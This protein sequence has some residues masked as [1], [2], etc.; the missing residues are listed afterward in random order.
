MAWTEGII[1]GAPL[2]AEFRL[3]FPDGR[4]VHLLARNAP[5]Y[6]KEASMKIAMHDLK[7]DELIVI[8]PG[9]KAYLL[10]ESIRVL[11]LESLA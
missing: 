5:I 6:E 3:R 2:S 1:K 8:Y 11:P 9:K 7:L 10:D 4:I